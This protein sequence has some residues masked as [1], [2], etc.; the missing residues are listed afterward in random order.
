MLMPN[1]WDHYFG[2]GFASGKSW[3]GALNDGDF[4][5]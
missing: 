4:I 1:E 5:R 2:R 3:K